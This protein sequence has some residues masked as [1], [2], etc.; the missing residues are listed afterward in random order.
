MSRTCGTDDRTCLPAFPL[1]KHALVPFGF[2]L[3]VSCCPKGLLL[4]TFLLSEEDLMSA[5]TAHLRSALDSKMKSV[6]PA[7]LPYLERYP[8]QKNAK[9]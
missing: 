1:Y 2:P 8:L 4:S 3:Q 7:P 6:P 9:R 5:E